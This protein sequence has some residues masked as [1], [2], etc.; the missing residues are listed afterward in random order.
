MNKEIY[1]I[2]KKITSFYKKMKFKGAKHLHEPYFDRF[3]YNEIKK[4]IINKQVSTYGNNVNKFEKQ[5][6]KITKSKY[7]IATINGTSALHLSLLTIKI[8][9]N[10]E[11]LLPSV[12]FIAA[13]NSIKYCRGIPHFV[14]SETDTLGVDVEKLGKYLKRNTKM[15]KNICINKKTNNTIKAIVCVHVFGLS[16]NIKS[17]VKLAKKYNILVIEDAAEALGSYNSNKHLGT[18]SDIGI[19]SFNGNKIITTGGGGALLTN[20]KSFAVR[21]KK[22]ST[23][24]KKENK[25][26]YDYAGVGYNYRMPSLNAALGC[27]QLKKLK[28]FLIKKRKLH[29]LLENELKEFSNKVQILKERKKC[30]SNYWLIALKLRNINIK[31]RDYLVTELRKKNIFCK[32]IWL[33]IDKMSFY[34][35]YPKTNLVNARKIEKTIITLPSSTFLK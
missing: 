13:A 8:K 5:I 34:R 35:K 31:E 11:I 17:L 32:P 9:K 22:L 26:N 18:Y 19:L 29:K 23:I 16:L 28:S 10:D 20:K 30:K 24:N 33:N 27:S 3:D 15:V 7:C 2:K 4:T 14:D 6:C 21:A 12:S 25:W 1:K